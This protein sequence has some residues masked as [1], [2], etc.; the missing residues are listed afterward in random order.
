MAG[1]EVQKPIKPLDEA[2]INIMMRYGPGPYVARIQETEGDITK[3]SNDIKSM[4]GVKEPD[5]GLAPPSYWDL[6]GD[7]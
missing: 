6:E 3:L 5:T 4:M 7:K 2:D 1:E